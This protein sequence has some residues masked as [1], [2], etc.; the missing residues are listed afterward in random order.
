MSSSTPSRRPQVQ[1][2]GL[3]GIGTA[4]LLVA[5]A[6]P[7][8]A[9]ADVVIPLAPTEVV[10]FSNPVENSGAV[11]MDPSADPT[12]GLSTPVPV[13]FTGSL[14]VELPAGLDS[15]DVE[16]DLVFDDNGDGNPEATY[17]SAFTPANP[18]FL[19]VAGQGTS[20]ITVTLPADDPMVGDD[21]V[22]V[23]EPL[24]T[25]YD[26]AVF[27]FVDPVSY[28][29]ALSAP[30]DPLD[31]AAVTVAPE[32]VA[33][34]SVP[35]PLSSTTPCPVAVTA[36]A[37]LVLDLTADSALRELGLTDLTGVDVAV[38]SIDD[39]DADPVLLDVRVSGST[40]TVAVPAGLAAGS[41]GL[42]LGQPFASGLSI[43][44]AELAV[45]APAA[46][47]A[48]STTAAPST[49]AVVANT[50]LRSNTGVVASAETGSTGTGTVAA[51]AGLLLLAGAG[52]FAVARTRRRPAAG[53]GTGEA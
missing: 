51:G 21:A 49:Q 40:A 41:Y 9:A 44:V 43:V 31:P 27:T 25:T 6:S 45:S 22:L 28:E 16:A 2:F 50:G 32:L 15:S 30:A 5:I 29:L 35:C 48:A 1:R 53:T 7:A 42:V 46:T 19:T 3:A 11:P 38:Q 23:L 34:A 37:N 20:S 26:P 52:G 12:A 10:L 17:S 24:T 39:P 13:E 33:L 47:P 4:V 14:T 36:G 8:G 18:Q